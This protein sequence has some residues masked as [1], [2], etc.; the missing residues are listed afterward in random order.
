MRVTAASS[1]GPTS[2]YTDFKVG[3]NNSA[4]LNDLTVMTF[5]ELHVSHAIVLNTKRNTECLNGRNTKCLIR[6]ITKCLI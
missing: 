4:F 6:R 2:Y 5:Q 1:E 3:R